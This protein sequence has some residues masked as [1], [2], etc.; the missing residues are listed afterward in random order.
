[1]PARRTSSLA[2]RA[3]GYSIV[4]VAAVV[5]KDG[6]G[7]ITPGRHRPDGCRRARRTGPRAVE[8]ALVGNEGTAESIAAAAAH[9]TDGVTVNGDIHADSEYRAAMAVVYTR[10][11]IEAALGRS[12]DRPS[13]GRVDRLAAGAARAADAGSSRRR[14]GSSA[15]CWRA[16]SSSA[17]SAGRRAG[18]CPPRTWPPGRRIR[19]SASG[20]SP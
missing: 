7:A 3:S 15:R 1:M 18:G 20:R 14:P 5:I 8:A 12:A 17:A 10:R 16:T 2:Q 11:A 9:A 4:G 6:G 13:T 19:R